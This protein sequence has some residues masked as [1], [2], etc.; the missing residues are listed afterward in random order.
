MKG[1]FEINKLENCCFGVY[2]SCVARHGTP[3]IL[4]NTAPS[5]CAI[6]NQQVEKLVL[7]SSQVYANIF[8]GDHEFF[9]S[10]NYLPLGVPFAAQWVKNP[11]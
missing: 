6:N 4:T 3:Q 11:T 7:I 9:Q 10:K 2:F 8:P 5:I 1:I